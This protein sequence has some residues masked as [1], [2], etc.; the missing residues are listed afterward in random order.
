M[1]L[2]VAFR[3]DASQAMGTGH[4]MRCLAL[5]D[6]VVA[7]GG[8]CLFI[9][10]RMDGNLIE[11]VVAKGYEVAA[12]AS[13]PSDATGAT[14]ESA[15]ADWLEVPSAI[16]AAETVEAL[17]STGPWAWLV[18]DHYA[19]DAAWHRAVR[20]AFGRLAV[21]DD[22]ANRSH[23]A[24]L[25]IDQNLSEAPTRY[26][27]KAPQSCTTLLGPRFALL[28]PEFA[29]IRALQPRIVG[30]S[31]RRVLVFLGGV[32]AP[33]ATLP[34]LAAL[35]T[36]RTSSVIAD[37]VIGTTNPNANAV[38]E[39][40]AGRPWVKVHQGGADLATLMAGAD[41]AIGAGGTTAL[42]RCVLGLPTL[43]I[44]IAD[45][46]VPGVS[47]LARRGATIN[48]GKLG[49]EMADQTLLVAMLRTLINS[50]DLRRHVAHSASA[51]VDGRGVGRVLGH[52]AAV[53]P[54]LRRAT[55]ADSDRIFAWRNAGETRRYFRDSR[56]IAAKD[57]DDWFAA[58][59]V[60]AD[61]DLLI[62][63]AEGEP[64]GVLRFDHRKN[65]AE[66]S[67]YLVP[68]RS[69]RGE[70]QRLLR[71]GVNWLRINR[72]QTQHVDAEVL[73]ANGQSTAA[74]LAA[75]FEPFASSYRFSLQEAQ[76]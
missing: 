38:V 1:S 33:G 4:V 66:V 14:A 41:I 21:I 49:L 36:V 31:V 19:I 37:V 6:A 35:E 9:M 64:I 18:V 26:A 10:R 67:I 52:L 45:N 55:A 24:D 60:D 11:H 8:C 50:E 39:W 57:H 62:G 75:G 32:D 30:P 29:K 3:V 58:A 22:L 61:R 5:A 59:L 2:R 68:G 17:T 72:P 63:E 70:G 20:P 51:L 47:A 12:L 7:G 46:Q 34:A 40:C 15:Y 43:T 65:A 48:A 25:L 69:G 16:D 53:N 73:A 71:A 44:I 13:P 76:L 74:F 28:R 54:V 27:G 42:E 56:Q 23:D